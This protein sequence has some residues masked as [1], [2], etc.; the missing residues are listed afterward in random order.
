MI[1]GVEQ[2]WADC[3]IYTVNLLCVPGTIE[4]AINYNQTY[5]HIIGL[6]Y[7]AF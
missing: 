1:K 7:N 3:D 2:A 5:Q 6:P 4:D